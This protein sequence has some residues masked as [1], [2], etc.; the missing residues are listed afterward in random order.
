MISRQ[1]FHEADDAGD[2]SGIPEVGADQVA[3]LDQDHDGRRAGQLGRAPVR[4]QLLV[5]LQ[6]EKALIKSKSLGSI[7]L[8]SESFML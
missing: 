1:R 5:D 3:V 4:S 8:P 2:T 6:K 7:T